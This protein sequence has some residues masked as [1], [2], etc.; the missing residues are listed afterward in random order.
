MLRSR[1]DKQSSHARE[2]ASMIRQHARSQGRGID[3]RV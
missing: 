1:F 3:T 2:L